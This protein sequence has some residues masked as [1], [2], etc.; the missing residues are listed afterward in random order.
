MKP[1]SLF[2]YNTAKAK[3]KENEIVCQTTRGEQSFMTH[4]NDAAQRENHQ[5]RDDRAQHDGH[6]RLAPTLVVQ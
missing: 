6:L 3:E 1:Q 2:N 4:L 5:Q